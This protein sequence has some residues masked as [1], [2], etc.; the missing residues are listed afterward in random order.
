MQPNTSPL[1][2]GSDGPAADSQRIA[3]LERQV[4]DLS[5]RVEEL[6]RQALVMPPRPVTRSPG[7]AA[8][9]EPSQFGE[10]PEALRGTV[11]TCRGGAVIVRA[12][13]IELRGCSL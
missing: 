3:A 5:A 7:E 11:I 2:P 9:G 13:G 4:A 6:A 12:E 1:Q 10:P 8:C